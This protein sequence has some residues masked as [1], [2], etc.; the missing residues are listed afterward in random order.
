METIYLFL[1]I[2]LQLKIASFIGSGINGNC[3]GGVS[4]G[5]CST[6]S[7]LLSEVELMETSRSFSSR[8]TSLNY[9]FFYRKWN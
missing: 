6:G 3:R 9:R 5:S 1:L 2:Y 4:T 7:L 8:P